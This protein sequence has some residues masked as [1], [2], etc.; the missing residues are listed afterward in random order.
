MT[1]EAR[2]NVAAPLPLDLAHNLLSALG[3]IYPNAAVRSDQSQYALS[4]LIPGQDRQ[5]AGPPPDPADLDLTG[6]AEPDDEASLQALT[7]GDGTLSA[8]VLMPSDAAL[9][10]G[11]IAAAMLADPEAVNYFEAVVHDDDGN[12]YV[13]TAARSTDQTPA[14]LLQAEKKRNEDLEA[15]IATLRAKVKATAGA[16]EA[17]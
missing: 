6:P 10:L 4:I 17:P 8:D 9:A 12:R 16:G 11:G 5:N 3:A 13:V 7:T 2:I 1:D 15:T 14:A